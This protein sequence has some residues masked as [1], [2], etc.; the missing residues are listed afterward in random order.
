[1]VRRLNLGAGK[2]PLPNSVNHD[3]TLHSPSIDFAWDLNDLP[4]P[5]GNNSFEIIVAHS[6]LEHLRLNLVESMAECWRILVPG[7]EICLKLPYYLHDFS[8]RDPTH[9]WKF[10]LT[11]FDVFDPS[12]K[13]G[14]YYDFYSPFKW[15]ITRKPEFNPSKSSIFVNLKTIKPKGA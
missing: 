1:M 9:Y 5:W 12:T 10:D 14:A 11:S 15:E 7:G 8:W 4:W 2:D 13:F 3:R 6:V